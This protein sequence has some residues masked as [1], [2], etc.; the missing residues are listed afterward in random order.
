MLRRRL[1]DELDRDGCRVRGLATDDE[2]PARAFVRAGAAGDGLV[3]FRLARKRAEP[4]SGDLSVAQRYD[5]GAVATG[6]SDERGDDAVEVGAADYVAGMVT[7]LA[8]DR[9]AV[10]DA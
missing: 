1:R 9:Q 10:S 4:G 2:L 6:P 8:R 5:A 7:H 3:V